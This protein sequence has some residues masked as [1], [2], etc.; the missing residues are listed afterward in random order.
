MA[1][2]NKNYSKQDVILVLQELIHIIQKFQFDEPSNPTAPFYPELPFILS[3]CF[4]LNDEL[5]EVTASRD[6]L[7]K[8]LKPSDDSAT[9][10][11]KLEELKFHNQYIDLFTQMRNTV[12]NFLCDYF[13]NEQYF[14]T[15]EICYYMLR[16]IGNQKGSEA[17]S[18]EQKA[19]LKAFKSFTKEQLKNTNPPVENCSNAM[20]KIRKL[21]GFQKHYSP[22]APKNNEDEQKKNKS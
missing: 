19:Q 4:S 6:A 10:S 13:N 22:R 8:S 1:T 11:R 7:S 21:C 3:I 15:G 17:L 14:S 12:W 18:T 20:R 16:C 9:K 5:L 2:K